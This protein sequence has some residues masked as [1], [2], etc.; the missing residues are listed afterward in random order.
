M[1][2]FSMKIAACCL[3]VSFCGDN[4]NEI[5]VTELGKF[6]YCLFVVNDVWNTIIIYR[7]EY[8]RKRYL[9]CNIIS[10]ATTKL[11]TVDSRS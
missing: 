9:R 8:F 4:T 10:L 7:H 6:A 3:H 2:L 1:I 5:R 11:M